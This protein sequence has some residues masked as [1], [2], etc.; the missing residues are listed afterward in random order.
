MPLRSSVLAACLVLC[1]TAVYAGAPSASGVLLDAEDV[2]NLRDVAFQAAREGDVE[3]LAA[4][5]DAGQPADIR[6]ARGDTLL[7]LATYYGHKNAAALILKQPGVDPNAVNAMGFTA[8][9]GAAFKGDL[10]TARLLLKQG[11]DPNGTAG[12]GRTP[13]MFAALFGRTAVAKVLFEHGADVAA[14][15]AAGATALSLAE[16][17]GNTAM[18]GLLREALDRKVS[19]DHRTREPVEAPKPRG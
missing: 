14:A 5:F 3:T 6:N 1:G 12:A 10:P 17:Q 19:V 9:T 7:I 8:L 4:Y 2:A 11:A 16:A 15:D 13:L 18:V